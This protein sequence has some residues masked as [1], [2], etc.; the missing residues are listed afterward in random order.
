MHAVEINLVHPDFLIDALHLSLAI[1]HNFLLMS[2]VYKA[3]IVTHL[4][5][6]FFVL[7]LDLNHGFQ[8]FTLHFP[9]ILLFIVS[10]TFDK[11][12]FLYMLWV[13]QRSNLI[14]F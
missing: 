1:N 12:D 5:S 10:L 13:L 7:P 2:E 6:L 9:E 8:I 4:L 11:V 14:Y 3:S